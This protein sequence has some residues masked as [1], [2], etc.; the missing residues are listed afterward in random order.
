MRMT[1][2]QAQV[3]ARLMRDA[4]GIDFRVWE[5]AHKAPGEGVLWIQ[6][7]TDAKPEEDALLI[8]TT[9]V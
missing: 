8:Y 1:M 3:R 2:Q 9:E 4:Y 6:A 5:A 7:V